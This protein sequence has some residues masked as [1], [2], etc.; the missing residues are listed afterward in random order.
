MNKSYDELVASIPASAYAQ[1]GRFAAKLSFQQRCEILALYRKGIGRAV[2]AEAYGIDRR[3]V[4]HIQNPKSPHY[5]SVRDEVQRLG[6]DLFSQT[7]ITESA[8]GRI[9]EVRN[10]GEY[11]D[12][13]KAANRLRGTH[14]M[15][16]EY[17]EYDHRVMIAWRDD[18][19][20]GPGWYYQD[21]DGVAPDEWLHNGEDSIQSSSAC[22]KAAEEVVSD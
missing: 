11:E 21:L 1:R 10:G 22:Y 4:T 6:N 20:L 5:K 19:H 13:K 12:P 2:L 14:I 8:V 15:R 9:A 17:C 16:N 7:Y 18:G 3:T